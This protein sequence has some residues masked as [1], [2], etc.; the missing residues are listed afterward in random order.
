MDC[1]PA[2]PLKMRLLNPLG[3]CFRLVTAKAQRLQ[4]FFVVFAATRFGNNVVNASRGPYLALTA[5]RLVV[6]YLAAELVPRRTIRLA[7]VTALDAVF[8]LL[9]SHGGMVGAVPI[10]AQTVAPGI[11]AGLMR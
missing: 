8:L 9:C 1:D 5:D 2:L 3:V 10:T 7:G 11:T 4:V 6:P